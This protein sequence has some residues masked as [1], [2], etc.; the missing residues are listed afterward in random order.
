MA[1]RKLSGSRKPQAVRLS[2]WMRALTASLSLA[3]RR[4][5]AQPEIAGAFEP[6]VALFE[7]GAVL[8]PAHLVNGPG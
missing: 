8:G 7:Q 6:G 1:A 3:Q 2:A 4:R 5:A